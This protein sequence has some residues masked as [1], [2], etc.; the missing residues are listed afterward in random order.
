MKYYLIDKFKVITIT[1]LILLII[2]S[3]HAQRKSWTTYF[4]VTSDVIGKIFVGKNPLQAKILDTENGITF[5]SNPSA[6]T[7]SSEQR[8][9]TIFGLNELFNSNGLKIADVSAEGLKIDIIDKS[10]LLQVDNGPNFVYAGL[11][12]DSSIVTFKRSMNRT[13]KTDP[14]IDK[15]K[16]VYPGIKETELGQFVDFLKANRTTF[17][18]TVFK[19]T[20][21]NPLVY[22][23][24]Q[25][26]KI[27]ILW[28]SNGINWKKQ[29]ASF[30][31]LNHKYADSLILENKVGSFNTKTGKASTYFS[32]FDKGNEAFVWFEINNKDSLEIHFETSYTKK[33]PPKVLQERNGTWQDEMEFICR[34]PYSSG[35]NNVDYKDVLLTYKASRKGNRIIIYS[36]ATNKICGQSFINYPESKL[37]WIEFNN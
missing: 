31:D 15:V 19:L 16:Q 22:F 21:K 5:K 1:I 28:N 20:I 18:T 11:R 30:L 3:L 9:T 12:A 4:P 34:Y 32:K 23:L 26:A 6:S 24:V 37:T 10:S 27:D 14:I 36:N 29:C 7:F 2:S 17:D 13:Y 25:V 33:S 35:K 8:Q